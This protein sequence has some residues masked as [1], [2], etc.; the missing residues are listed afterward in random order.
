M[1]IV[2]SNIKYIVDFAHQYNFDAT[3]ALKL[4]DA[5][6][7]YYNVNTTKDSYNSADAAR[8]DVCNHILSLYIKQRE[9]NGKN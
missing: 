6:E 9:Q 3:K 8:Q 1:Y 2:R 7:K 4:Y 5:K